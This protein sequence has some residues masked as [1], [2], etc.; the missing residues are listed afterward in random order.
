MTIERPM[1][2]PLVPAASPSSRRTILFGLAAAG[3]GAAPAVALPLLEAPAVPLAETA[4]SGLA[5]AVATPSPDAGLLQTFDEYLAAWSDL[6]RLVRIQG[7][8][9]KKH[10]AATPM[11]DVLPVQPGDANLGLPGLPEQFEHWGCGIR[12]QEIQEMVRDGGL[13]PAARA[14]ADEIV[15]AHA[16][17]RRQRDREP[18]APA[19][20]LTPKGCCIESG[21][22]PAG[23]NRPYPRLHHRRVGRESAS[24]GDR[25]QG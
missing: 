18:A 8:Q 17:W 19:G 9:E 12:M 24:C 11:P 14:R 20:S 4:A 13:P 3:V 22:S 10:W 1:F 7:H 23:Q 21:R 5:P 25:G 16:K 2:P 6:R 15:K